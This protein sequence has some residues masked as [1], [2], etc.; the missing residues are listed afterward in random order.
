MLL[1]ME[2]V[3][4]LKYC[5]NKMIVCECGENKFFGFYGWFYSNDLHKNCKHSYN[6]DHKW[7]ELMFRLCE[8][9]FLFIRKSEESKPVYMFGKYETADISTINHLFFY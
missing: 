1:Y 2:L 6:L 8:N 4:Y 3:V 5:G 7:I 9:N